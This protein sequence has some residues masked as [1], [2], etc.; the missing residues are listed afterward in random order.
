MLKPQ[1]TMTGLGKIRQFDK[2]WS[3]KAEVECGIMNDK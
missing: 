2:I 3:E 1:N